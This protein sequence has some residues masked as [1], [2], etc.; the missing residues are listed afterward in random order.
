MQLKGDEG[1]TS[2]PICSQSICNSPSSITGGNIRGE[3]LGISHRKRSKAIF[4][5]ISIAFRL[6]WVAMAWL[7]WG[8]SWD[9]GIS[10]QGYP[11]IVE[12][13]LIGAT[14]GKSRLEN[15]LQRCTFLDEDEDGFDVLLVSKGWICDATSSYIMSS[16]PSS[17]LPTPSLE[18]KWNIKKYGHI[19]TKLSSLQTISLNVS[20]AEQFNILLMMMICSNFRQ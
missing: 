1:M 3:R 19:F 18:E 9:S 10:R 16:P 2:V 6:F 17:F 20:K 7:E 11:K 12:I 8:I 4:I 13:L 14:E 5:C 15:P